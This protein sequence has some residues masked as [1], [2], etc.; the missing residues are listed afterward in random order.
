VN[1]DF[2]VAG[3]GFTGAV[4]AR[5]LSDKG[6]KGLVVEK[7]GL[8]GGNCYTEYKEGLEF[9]VYGPHLFHTSDDR[10]WDFLHGFTAFCQHDHRVYVSHGQRMYSFPINLMTLHQLW[11]VRTPEEALAKLE[12]V[13]VPIQD[14]KNLEEWCLS[15]V[16]EEIYRTFIHGYT[17]KQWNTEPSLLPSSI[18][19]RI[20]IRLTY[21]NSYF[22]DTYQGLP[23]DGYT[24]IFERLLDGIEVVK[25]CDFLTDPSLSRKGR[26]IFTGKIDE[27]YGYRFGPLAYR[28]LRFDH[29]RIEG[30][31]QGSS[32]INYTDEAVPYT[33]IVEHKHFG[34]SDNPVSIA[35]VEYPD[36]YEEGKE[37]Y[38]PVGD[39]Q[40]RALYEKYRAIPTDVVFA[41]RLGSYQYW[42]MDKAIA[43]SLALSDSL[44]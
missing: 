5:I 23:K 26:I 19:R 36:D 28:S 20:P 39:E 44:A 34:H 24:A 27:F 21:N 8:I 1:Y 16:G 18:I 32:V 7:R 38:Y 6:K 12:S 35:T 13:R 3:S 37:A 11:G 31:Y 43:A 22:S 10:V 15:Q 33:R 4:L 14:P 40:N 9:H 42:D 41:G 2:V 30:D 25:D 29:I 17:K